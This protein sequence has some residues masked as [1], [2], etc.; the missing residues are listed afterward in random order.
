MII[1]GI[2]LTKSGFIETDAYRES[3]CVGEGKR[4]NQYGA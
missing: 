1:G 3:L 2:E 4:R